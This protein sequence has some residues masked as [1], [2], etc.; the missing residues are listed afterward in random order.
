MK[1]GLFAFLD[2]QLDNFDL[3]IELNLSNNISNGRDNEFSSNT[4]FSATLENVSEPVP[5]SQSK[6][7]TIQVI[8]MK[9]YE[10]DEI[11]V[12]DI[13]PKTSFDICCQM[14]AYEILSTIDYMTDGI[15]ERLC[16][17]YTVDKSLVNNW[18]KDSVSFCFPCPYNS[19]FINRKLNEAFQSSSAL[20]RSWSTTKRIKF[21][22]D[23]HQITDD[24][25]YL[26]KRASDWQ[27]SIQRVLNSY[28]N[29]DLDCFYVLRD[30]FS[31]A[32]NSNID[33]IP[34]TI[35]QRYPSRSSNRN[36]SQAKYQFRC[37][38]EGATSKLIER[39]QAYHIKIMKVQSQ[40][41]A[42]ENELY[43]SN[44]KIWS[45]R[46]VMDS[47]NKGTSILI[48]GQQAIR[49]LINIYLEQVTSKSK[50][51][52]T[53]ELPF[54]IASK[55]FVNSFPIVPA[56]RHI[57]SPTIDYSR[58]AARN[59]MDG[60][61]IAS[62]VLEDKNYYRFEIQGFFSSKS[63]LSLYKLIKSIN[64]ENITKFQIADID[65]K[66]YNKRVE[67]E[68]PVVAATVI[69][70]PMKNPFEIVTA[71]SD[72]F[73][74]DS[75]PSSSLSQSNMLR[76]GD[77]KKDAISL[78]NMIDRETWINAITQSSDTKYLS[79]KLSFNFNQFLNFAYVVPILDSEILEVNT[80]KTYHV[81]SELRWYELKDIEATST[82]LVKNNL[83]DPLFLAISCDEPNKQ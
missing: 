34:F 56:L 41:S 17:K 49:V 7:G 79:I 66:W 14:N 51:K 42:S 30:V 31:K 4:P 19:P 74:S 53:V 46:G 15:S 54:M 45:S 5:Q 57:H 69:A 81:M 48:E 61:A 3:N 82:N 36:N 1:R 23:F 16:A 80:G 59:D 9:D 22:D 78:S 37:I 76:T 55:R 39:L 40:K 71:P 2:S 25:S 13:I 28:F 11:V 10:I 75:L 60:N 73:L 67:D 70:A 24:L 32:I 35:F 8:S 50:R 33:T 64:G 27:Q 62:D 63:L 29:G 72:E 6:T 52:P 58:S 65:T 83:S 43:E 12:E 77:M 20:P 47:W 26:M 68:M 21:D 44:R 38:I 18:I